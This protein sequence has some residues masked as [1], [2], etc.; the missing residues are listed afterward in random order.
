MLRSL[1]LPTRWEMAG[2]LR[3][4]A[5]RSST[6]G[7]PTKKPGERAS[8]ASISASHSTI[9]TTGLNTNAT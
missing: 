8:V 3:S 4:T 9:G 6:I 1:R 7:L 5:A 2:P